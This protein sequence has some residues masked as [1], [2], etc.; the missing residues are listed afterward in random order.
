[1]DYS[2]VRR[3]AFVRY[4]FET[5]VQQSR[6]LTLLNGASILT[7]HDAVELFP[8]LARGT[9]NAGA[10]HPGFIDYSDPLNPKLD[11]QGTLAEGIDATTQQG[12][13]GAQA[14]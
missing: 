3:L 13:R 11:P 8:Q 2:T 12:S 14:S 5:V 1:M 7:A 6:L 9:L 4:L 10:G